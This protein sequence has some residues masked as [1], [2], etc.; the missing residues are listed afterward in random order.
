MGEISTLADTVWVVFSNLACILPAYKAWRRGDHGLSAT[1]L[2][3]GL[4]SG[5]FHSCGDAHLAAMCLG[6]TTGTFLRV[7]STLSYVSI[8][9]TIM[10]S[11]IFRFVRPSVARWAEQVARVLVLASVATVYAVVE[12]RSTADM[13]AIVQIAAAVVLGGT[14]YARFAV[15]TVKYGAGYGE[16]NVVP[17]HAALATALT[18]SVIAA[19]ANRLAT[20]P[21][22]AGSYNFFHGLW[23]QA[24]YLDAWAALDI[25]V[26]VVKHGRESV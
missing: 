14:L 7:D 16:G 13:F 24:V 19:L 11:A 23:H 22:L 3:S 2:S 12:E 25:G 18:T 15:Y 4:V 26:V 17:H 9:F 8:I 5:V 21:A 1:Y 6:M 10:H 20:E